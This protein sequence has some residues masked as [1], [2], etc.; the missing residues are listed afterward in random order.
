MKLRMPGF[1][2]IHAAFCLTGTPL[3]W[4]QTPTDSIRE[5]VHKSLEIMEDPAY[6]Q[7]EKKMELIHQLRR[8]VFPLFDFQEMARRSLG[9]HWRSLTPGQKKDFTAI[10]TTFLEGSYA[11][12]I[13]LYNGQKVVFI[14]EKVDG[15][16]AQVRSTIIGRNGEEYSVKYNLLQK[17]GSWKIYDLVA[18]NIS[19]VNN[20]R[21][22]FNRV[23][24]KSSYDELLRRLE[25]KTPTA[26]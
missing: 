15:G 25:E 21:S 19:L 18:E 11:D 22:Q 4:A 16:Y 13:N 9:R 8:V 17:G 7:A 10:F 26:N 1:G 3:L 20:Y 23:I 5:A 14:G 6:Q 2:V 24:V 12:K